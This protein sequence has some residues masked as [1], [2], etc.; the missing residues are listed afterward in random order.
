MTELTAAEKA[1]IRR[2]AWEEARGYGPSTDGSP[3][4]HGGTFLTRLQ[5]A[6]AMAAWVMS[7]DLPQPP[8]T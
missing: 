8:R 3:A 2:W 4:K 7:G 1:E 5:T 6:D